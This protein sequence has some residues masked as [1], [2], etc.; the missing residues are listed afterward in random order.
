MNKLILILFCFLLF[1]CNLR[2]EP[3]SFD[4]SVICGL[5][6]AIF[7]PDGYF[8]NHLGGLGI[9]EYSFEE[10]HFVNDLVGFQIARVKSN[11]YKRSLFKTNDGGV[12]WDVV[13]LFENS[14]VKSIVFK[15]A[16]VGILF[17]SSSMAW[18]TNDGGLT[19][20]PISSTINARHYAYASNG[21]IYSSREDEIFVSNTDGKTWTLLSDYPDFDFNRTD[22]SFR[23]IQDKI[24]A[25]GKDDSI[26]VIDLDGNYIASLYP[27]IRVSNIYEID[28]STFIVSSYNKMVI[29]KDGGSNWQTYYDGVAEMLSLRSENN[30]I[31]L[32]QSS[33]KPVDYIE[34]Y[35]KIAYT[36]DGGQTWIQNENTNTNLLLDFESSQSMSD[37]RAVF[38]VR[39]CLFEVKKIQ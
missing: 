6:Q 39:N 38:F 11:S 16:D 10:S 19:W 15:D 35:D 26:I 25:L 7:S 33:V 29:T 23:I 37:N 21:N 1:G 31:I 22:F 4:E 8:V 12:T 5:N 34:T 3:V 17:N 18:K 28:K 24:Y 36:E 13:K 30:A 20:T 2:E 9:S 32:M 27:E 14:N